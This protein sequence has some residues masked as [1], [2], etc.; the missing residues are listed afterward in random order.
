MDNNLLSLQFLTDALADELESF[1][2]LLDV[3]ERKRGRCAITSCPKYRIASEKALFRDRKL[4][5]S[6][7]V[8]RHQNQRY[9][10][11]QILSLVGWVMT[12]TLNPA[13]SDR[14]REKFA[15]VVRRI[16]AQMKQP[17]DHRAYTGPGE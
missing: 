8:T 3:I 4:P 17:P 7:R 13:N 16:R 11:L 15:D 12:P 14:L 10:C 5:C 1:A 2:R 6:G 9:L